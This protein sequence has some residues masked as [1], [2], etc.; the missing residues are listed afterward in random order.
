MWPPKPGGESWHTVYSLRQ[1]VSAE[2]TYDT[3]NALLGY[4]ANFAYP[5]QLVLSGERAQ[6]GIDGLLV[7]TRTAQEEAG[8]AAPPGPAR[9]LPLEQQHTRSTT[10]ERAA[11]QSLFNRDESALVIEF[12][13]TLT[14]TTATRRSSTAGICDILL[15][16]PGGRELVEA[17]SRIERGYV[18]E[19]LAQLLDYARYIPERIDRLSA[20]FPHPLKATERDLLHHYGIDIIQRVAP[21]TFERVPAPT[22][23]RELMRELWGRGEQSR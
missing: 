20:L 16:G 5:G 11:Q 9:E 22:E 3:L 15:V 12:C 23:A 17:K 14:D 1:F 6:A 4:K 10:I 2:I 7:T 18:R 8:A 13:R 21:S 19:A